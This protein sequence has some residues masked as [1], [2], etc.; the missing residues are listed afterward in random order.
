MEATCWF[1]CLDEKTEVQQELDLCKVTARECK[2]WALKLDP[3]KPPTVLF[4]PDYA[5]SIRN[6]RLGDT[7]NPSSPVCD[8]KS[9]SSMQGRPTPGPFHCHPW[10]CP[11]KPTGN[12]SWYLSGACFLSSRRFDGLPQWQVLLHLRQG[13]GLSHHQLCSVLQG[14]LLV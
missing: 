6:A 7:H 14:G 1:H 10:F 8:P 2:T 11:P 3:P 9:G 12:S 13:H 5:A 4:L